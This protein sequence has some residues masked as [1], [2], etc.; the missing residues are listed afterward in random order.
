MRCVRAPCCQEADRKKKQ[1]LSNGDM[2][3]SLGRKLKQTINGPWSLQY[4]SK[5]PTAAPTLY[6]LTL[7]LSLVGRGGSTSQDPGLCP[8]ATY[9]CHPLTSLK[10]QHQYGEHLKRPFVFQQYGLT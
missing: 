5:I 9:F 2:T 7:S 3:C 6:S 1:T 4:S 10:G 8:K